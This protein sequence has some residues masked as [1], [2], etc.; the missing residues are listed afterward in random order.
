MNSR[1]FFLIFIVILFS[2][3]AQNK[4]KNKIINSF[5]ED[6]PQTIS[7]KL[8]ISDVHDLKLSENASN[9]EYIKLETNPKSLIAYGGDMQ[10]SDDYLFINNGG[11]LKQFDQ[12]GKF[13]RQ[14][15]C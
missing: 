5:E 1:I 11:I 13:I 4:E 6:Y 2:C 9:I 12:S 3:S 14:I 15:N 7:L 8:P 10:F